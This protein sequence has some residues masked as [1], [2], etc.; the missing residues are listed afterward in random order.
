M[1]A[2]Q[3]ECQRHQWQALLHTIIIRT[4]T[5][6]TLGTAAESLTTTTQ[7]S[8]LSACVGVRCTM[9]FPRQR[10]LYITELEGMIDQEGHLPIGVIHHQ[11]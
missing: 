8:Q 3:L 11:A 4:L 7:V 9:N 5:S 6:P 1:F 10:V 2:D